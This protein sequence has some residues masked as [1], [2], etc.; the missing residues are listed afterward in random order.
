MNEQLDNTFAM[1]DEEEEEVNDEVSK[2]LM[3][4][5]GVQIQ[6]MNIVPVGGL[7]QED[8]EVD[9]ILKELGI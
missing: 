1:N 2:V 8:K 3:E 6:G 7:T 5:A 9:A 4:V